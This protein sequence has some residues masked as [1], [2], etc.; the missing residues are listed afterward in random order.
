MTW[1]WR[2]IRLKLVFQIRTDRTKGWITQTQS[3]QGDKQPETQS[4]WN[5]RSEIKGLLHFTTH[6]R[7]FD[8]WQNRTIFKV[9]FG[10]ENPFPS[11]MPELWKVFNKL[12]HS[13]RIFTAHF[14][15]VWRWWPSRD[16]I[17]FEAVIR[18]GCSFHTKDQT[19]NEVSKDKA[20]HK[21]HHEKTGS[22][23]KWCMV[24]SRT[25]TT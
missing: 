18:G 24:L 13:R 2:K 20:Y 19:D 7:R 5:I 10:K 14:V 25:T 21:K 23:P 11:I 22:Y 12:C 16:F 1:K 15:F 4:K 9:G 3:P 8:V 17:I 6:V